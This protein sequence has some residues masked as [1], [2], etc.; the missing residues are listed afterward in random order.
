MY[1]AC[2]LISYCGYEWRIYREKNKNMVELIIIYGLLIT[3]MNRYR[4]KNGKA[5]T[6]KM[7]GKM[8]NFI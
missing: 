8:W 5:K 2:C 7:C 1:D 3:S 6:R 4:R